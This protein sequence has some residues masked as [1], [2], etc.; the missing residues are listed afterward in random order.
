MNEQ[1][2]HFRPTR[3]KSQILH[4][5]FHSIGELDQLREVA[6]GTSLEFVQLSPGKL[7]GTMAHMLLPQ[8]SL[9]LNQLSL[10]VR[11]RGEAANDRWSFVIFPPQVRGCFNGIRLDS[12]KILVYPPRSE[13]EGTV[14]GSGEFHDWVLTVTREALAA[15]YFALSQQEL[16]PLRSPVLC[17]QPSSYVLAE[18]RAFVCDLL[19]IAEQTPEILYDPTI[20]LSLQCQLV[21]KLAH[22][23]ATADSARYQSSDSDV[24]QRDIVRKVEDFIE[25]HFGEDLSLAKLCTSADVSERTLRRAF[26]NFLGISPSCFLKTLR[27][28]HA[29]R[30]L[31]QA[32]PSETQVAVVA[33]KCGLTHLGRFSQEYKQFFGESPSTTLKRVPYR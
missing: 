10:P 11:A 33:M 4:R 32:F 24:S 22:A 19:H 2:I 23:L 3:E 26:A 16:P 12:E 21:E 9:H 7:K 29:Y 20:D 5:A 27:M 17:L 30:E 8:S 25:S 14:I 1:S 28:N 6:H 15:P 31:Q 18:L 13:F